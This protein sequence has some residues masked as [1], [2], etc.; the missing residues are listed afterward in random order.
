MSALPAQKVS[1]EDGGDMFSFIAS[2]WK[3]AARANSRDAQIQACT[4]SVTD[5]ETQTDLPRNQEVSTELPLAVY[6]W[7][8][9]HTLFFDRL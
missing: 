4:I 3:D 5:F 8:L 9:H 2:T 1:F 6:V 7:D